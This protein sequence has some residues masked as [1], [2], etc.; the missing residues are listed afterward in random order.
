MRKTSIVSAVLLASVSSQALADDS[1]AASSQLPA[2]ALTAVASTPRRDDLDVPQRGRLIE[3]HGYYAAPSLGVT[4]FDGVAAPV[5]GVRT[6]WLVNHSFGLGAAFN[7]TGNE[8]DEKIDY[9]G[10]ALGAFGGVLLQY[11]VGASHAVHGSVD[12]TVG[13]GWSCRYTGNTEGD[14]DECHG[15]GF[16]MLEPMAN[17][18]FNLAKFMRLSLGAGYRV[19]I[20]GKS[21]EFSNGELSGFVGRTNLQFGRF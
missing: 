12:T 18:E 5:L 7:L 13:G 2:V 21:N 11:V 4:S 8:L 1:A 6:A 3:H 19:G 17:V 9:K 16:F 15:R 14:S 20:A 10:R